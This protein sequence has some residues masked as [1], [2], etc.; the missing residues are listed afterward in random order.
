MSF[1]VRWGHGVEGSRAVAS[2]NQGPGEK[3]LHRKTIRVK[4]NGARIINGELTN[5]SKIFD[6]LR[7]DE[8][9]A[10]V[11]RNRCTSESKGTNV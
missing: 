5:R 11:K 3:I 2:K 7:N 10:K 1:M 6:N 8:N 9:I 4:F